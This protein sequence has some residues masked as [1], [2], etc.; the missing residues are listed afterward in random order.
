MGLGS[1]AECGYRLGNVNATTAKKARQIHA[2]IAKA[3]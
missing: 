1:F 3:E 2:M